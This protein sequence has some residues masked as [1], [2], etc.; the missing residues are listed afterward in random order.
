[1]SQFVPPRLEQFKELTD[2]STLEFTVQV[3]TQHFDVQASGYCCQT[4]DLWHV[5]VAAAAQGSTIEATCHELPAAPHSNT[6][7]NTVRGYLH[8]QLTTEQVRPLEADFGS[9]LQ[10]CLGQSTAPLVAPPT[11]AQRSASSHR[12][13]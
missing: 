3:L 12:F 2:Q 7:R 5:L 1:M 4:R 11:A 8:D 10:L 13:S 9:R 6:V